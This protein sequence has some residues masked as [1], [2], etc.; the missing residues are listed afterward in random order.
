M[1]SGE[2]YV[3]FMSAEIDRWYIKKKERLSLQLIHATA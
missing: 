3:H 1:L 2:Q